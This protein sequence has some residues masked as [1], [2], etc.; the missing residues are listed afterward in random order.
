MYK[1]FRAE[2]TLKFPDGCEMSIIFTHPVLWGSKEHRYRMKVIVKDIE[3]TYAEHDL[4][5]RPT[6]SDEVTP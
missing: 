2:E 6:R 3:N 4:H 5:S 1:L